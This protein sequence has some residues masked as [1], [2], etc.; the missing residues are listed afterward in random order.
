MQ[1][2]GGALRLSF[3]SD[4]RSTIDVWVGAGK[5][6]IPVIDPEIIT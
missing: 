6:V 4:K 2:G 1:G 5:R 3:D